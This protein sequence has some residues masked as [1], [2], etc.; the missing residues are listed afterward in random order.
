MQVNSDLTQRVVILPEEYQFTESPLAGV[1]PMM[2]DRAGDEVARATSVVR[3]APGSAYSAH[4]H[5][6]GEEI[7]E[8][9]LSFDLS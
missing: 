6:G 5:D 1:S 8:T 9:A 2:L 7:W 4:T 3:Y